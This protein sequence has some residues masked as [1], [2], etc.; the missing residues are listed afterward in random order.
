MFLFDFPSAVAATTICCCCCYF[1]VWQ[2]RL[3]T[4]YIHSII[5]VWPW[6]LGW[7]CYVHALYIYLASVLDR[8]RKLVNGC[9][10]YFKTRTKHRHLFCRAQCMH[11]FAHLHLAEKTG[12][13]KNTAR[14]WHSK[15]DYFVCIYIYIWVYVCVFVWHTIAFETKT[16][17]LVSRF[18]WCRKSNGRKS[19]KAILFVWFDCHIAAIKLTILTTQLILSSLPKL[20]ATLPV[21]F[22]YNSQTMV[23]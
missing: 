2:R 20:D 23:F 19:F 9:S 15:F 14:V 17:N 18:E 8:G 16:D 4:P 21:K 3:S 7:V 22:K 6:F 1:C 10:A 13:N 12:Q 11:L 5:S